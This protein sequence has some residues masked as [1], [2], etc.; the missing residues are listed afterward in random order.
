MFDV[1][2][3]FVYYIWYIMHLSSAIYFIF[4]FLLICWLNTVYNTVIL[5]ETPVIAAE[6]VEPRA[7]PR[8]LHRTAVSLSSKE[9]LRAR[10]TTAS[11][12][13]PQRRIGR[14]YRAF[15]LVS[16]KRTCPTNG[17]VK[18][19]SHTRFH[20]ESSAITGVWKKFLCIRWDRR[21]KGEVS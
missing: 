14:Q 16:Q 1:V 18:R 20:T 17:R 11:R 9:R 8:R 12:P 4:F 6:S 5:Y 2:F 21:R 10:C 13:G 3:M 7:I 19:L 15:R